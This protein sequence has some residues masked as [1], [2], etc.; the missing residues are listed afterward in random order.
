MLE[1]MVTERYEVVR[2]ERGDDEPATTYGDLLTAAVARQRALDHA[3]E[4]VRRRVDALSPSP[5]PPTTTNPNDVDVTGFAVPLEADDD[6]PAPGRDPRAPVLGT[7][8]ANPK[9]ATPSPA[10]VESG[11]PP[12][13]IRRYLR[14]AMGPI[15]ACYEAALRTQP[16]LEGTVRVTFTIGADGR[17]SSAAASGMDDGAAACIAGVI[18]GLEFPRPDGGGVVT[19]RY[20]FVFR[21]AM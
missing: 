20:P 2:A 4:T 19:V 7:P 21:P 1:T 3:N 8:S 13:V 17:V 16:G 6:P 11:L 18:R 10:I 9:N 12:A 14:R 15:R 5:P